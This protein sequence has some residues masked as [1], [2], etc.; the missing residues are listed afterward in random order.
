MAVRRSISPR[1]QSPD[2]VFQADD[3]QAS[4]PCQHS[5]SSLVEIIQLM[6]LWSEHSVWGNAEDPLFAILLL[7]HVFM[8]SVIEFPAE[9]DVVKE[10]TGRTLHHWLAMILIDLF[11]HCWKED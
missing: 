2:C 10:S 4:E 7:T 3:L 1:L 8:E 5:S 9:P 6:D 11:V